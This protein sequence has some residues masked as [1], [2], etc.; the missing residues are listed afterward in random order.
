MLDFKKLIWL[1]LIER[2]GRGRSTYYRR[3]RDET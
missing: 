3:P 2:Q 1:G